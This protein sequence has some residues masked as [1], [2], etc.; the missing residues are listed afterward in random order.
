MLLRRNAPPYIGAWI[1]S[2]S[3]RPGM[4]S[5][6]VDVLGAWRSSGRPARTH[7][8]WR[9]GRGRTA[10]ASLSCWSIAWTTATIAAATSGPA[11]PWISIS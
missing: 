3:D 5:Y 2:S 10:A 1:P 6:S 9:I 4:R 8:L 11:P 7:W